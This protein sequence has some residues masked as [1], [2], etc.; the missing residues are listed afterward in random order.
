MCRADDLAA[1]QAEAARWRTAYDGMR[2]VAQRRHRTL[3]LYEQTDAHPQFKGRQ[4]A[5]GALA[6]AIAAEARRTGLTTGLRIAIGATEKRAGLA[7]KQVS[8]VVKA[9]EA[10]GAIACDRPNVATA[11]GY[12]RSVLVDIALPLDRATDPS[13]VHAH[14][15]GRTPR[16][17]RV[18]KTGKTWGGDRPTC[19]RCGPNAV[20]VHERTDTYRCTDCGTA[21]HHSEGREVERYRNGDERPVLW[22]LATGPTTDPRQLPPAVAGL[23]DAPVTTPAGLGR[24]ALIDPA[25]GVVAVDQVDGGRRDFPADDVT[26]LRHLVGGYLKRGLLRHLVGVGSRRRPGSRG[27]ARR[28]GRR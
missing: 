8:T 2:R 4:R 20:I 26:L 1:A 11:A 23:L 24:V 6:E 15:L 10:G 21:L 25:A 7:E 16:A 5:V 28:P 9:A 14:L 22:A 27:D 3:L 17:P 18:G 19:R 12:R 13:A